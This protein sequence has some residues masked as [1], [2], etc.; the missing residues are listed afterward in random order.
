ME[1]PSAPS[2]YPVLQREPRERRACADAT[3]AQAPP[4]PKNPPNV[5]QGYRLDLIH[6]LQM[7]LETERDQQ[8]TL[9]KKYHRSID[10]IDAVDTT[11]IAISTG[12]GIGG[13]GLLTTVVAA[14][15]VL[16]LEIGAAGCGIIAVAGKCIGRRIATKALKHDKMRVLADSKINT[17][18]SY[19]SKA[20]NDGEIT[21]LEFQMIKG[22][23]EKYYTLKD[24]IRRSH[25]KTAAVSSSEKRK[26]IQLGRDEAHKSFM[27]K[28][29][30]GN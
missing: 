26:L 19:V 21:D 13:V 2:L 1:A 22:E 8:R 23:L 12:L 4:L 11:L 6:R 18:A 15:I 5:A 3:T 14:P 9:C 24:E 28:I 10:M 16:G 20:L 25:R 27:K 17:I 7:Q 30:G 29:Q